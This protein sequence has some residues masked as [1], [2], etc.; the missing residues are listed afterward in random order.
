MTGTPMP[1]DAVLGTGDGVRRRFE[2]IKR[3]GD[4][5]VR[6]ITRP[7]TDSIM[8]S[9]DGASATDWELAESG[10][11]EFGEPP[12]PGMQI[13]AGFLFD[14]PVRFEEP[15]LKVSQKSYLAGALASVPLIEVREA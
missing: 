10:V 7:V 12:G 5:E 11:I 1:T 9:L 6:R 14:V 2:L 15:S 8:I 13:Q 3:Y 4:G